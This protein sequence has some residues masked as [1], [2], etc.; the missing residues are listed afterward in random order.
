[1][2]QNK[3][4]A[5]YET[6]RRDILA[7]RLRPSLPLKLNA[8]RDRYGFGWTPL[9]EALSRLEAERLVTATPNRGF[10]VA[11]VSRAD[12]EDLTRARLVVELP[13][14]EE[15]IEKGDSHW[16]DAIVTAH[17]RLSRCKSPVEDPT[18]EGITLWEQKH[19]A[20]HAALL[21]AS[22]ARWLRLL[23]GQIQDQLRRHQRFLTITPTVNATLG[24]CES[25]EAIEAL[26]EATA[27]KPHTS[28]MEAALDRN[29]SAA[30]TLL[31]K[32]IG[33][34]VWAFGQSKIKEHSDAKSANGTRKPKKS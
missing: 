12:L 10:F 1:M 32:H 14:F 26:R 22:T 8:L 27:I 7:A 25:S 3:T 30:R 5:A 34:T 15:A 21:S 13:L 4:D 18:D 33:S 16:E 31:T 2:N 29:I 9:R 17:F 19:E 11:P 23:H 28:L 20:F 24:S 6:L